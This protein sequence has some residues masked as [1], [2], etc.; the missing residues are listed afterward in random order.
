[1]PACPPARPCADLQKRQ[2][3]CSAR[4][5][6]FQWP[7]CKKSVNPAGC[8]Y[9]DGREMCWKGRHRTRKAVLTGAARSK[10]GLRNC[11]ELTRP[12]GDG[13]WRDVES[14]E[15]RV[16]C[17]GIIVFPTRP[18]D[19]RGAQMV[20]AGRNCT[21]S[22]R[23]TALEIEKASRI[24]LRPMIRLSRSAPLGSVARR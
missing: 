16:H 4:S 9:R 6:R 15:Q 5:A 8:C 22:S 2:R 10:G 3:G 12:A 23:K 13:I 1:M 17:S 24:C 19:C 7:S 18:C 20:D 11:G 21:L 14:E